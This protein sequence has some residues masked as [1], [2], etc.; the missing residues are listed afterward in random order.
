[1]D[2]LTPTRD[3]ALI[4]IHLVPRASSSSVEGTHG[5]ALTVRLDAPPVDGKA[6]R[7]LVEFVAER[8]EIPRS[9]VVLVRG[10]TSRAKTLQVTGLAAETIRSRLAPV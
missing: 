2:W 10:E 5:D 6:N 8:L 1:M 7:A 4:R 3:G 9:A